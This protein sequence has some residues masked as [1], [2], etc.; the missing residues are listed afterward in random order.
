MVSVI[1]TNTREM[2]M[3]DNFHGRAYYNEAIMGDCYIRKGSILSP[4]ERGIA[5]MRMSDD[6]EDRL[7][8]WIDDLL[9]TTGINEV[10]NVRI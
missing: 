3:K 8:V 7:K 9:T 2:M 4:T 10:E 5:L 1:E 6:L